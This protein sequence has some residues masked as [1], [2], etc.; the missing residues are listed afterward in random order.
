MGHTTGEVLVCNECGFEVTVTK[1]CN[2]DEKCVINCCG[3]P[4]QEK[5]GPEKKPG[6]CCCG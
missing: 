1:G 5:S 2:C 6:C 3:K 4:M